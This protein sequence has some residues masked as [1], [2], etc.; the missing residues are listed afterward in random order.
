MKL[1]EYLGSLDF[2]NIVI[3]QKNR[4]YAKPYLYNAGELFYIQSN[5]NSLV[6]LKFQL[7]NDFQLKTAFN[8]NKN[9][10]KPFNQIYIETSESVGFHPPNEVVEFRFNGKKTGF[11]FCNFYLKEFYSE[12][13]QKLTFSPDYVQDLYILISAGGFQIVP[14]V[15]NNRARPTY[16]EF[17]FP[18]SY[19][20]NTNF[21]CL[22]TQIPLRLSSDNNKLWR[23][24]IESLEYPTNDQIARISA[25]IEKQH[26][27]RNEI[28]DKLFSHY[29][30]TAR[31]DFE[32]PE[33]TSV[34][35]LKYFISEGGITVP[36]DSN[37]PI[38]IF[39]NTWDEEHGAT[40]YFDDRHNLLTEG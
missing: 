2:N 17:E 8:L 29:N 16:L 21:G 13:G 24:E 7:S 12:D 10:R 14:Y 37:E 11:L 31:F 23:L 26:S 28:W 35:T 30:S 25:F 5:D 27:L 38:T 9:D 19:F 32:L 22:E 36:L 20:Y 33:L 6:K 39:I 15:Y 34:E 4:N 40:F 1:S 18:L 3:Y